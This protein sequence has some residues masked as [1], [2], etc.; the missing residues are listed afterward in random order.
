MAAAPVSWEKRSKE[1]AKYEKAHKVEPD[2]AD[3][4]QAAERML[5]L[6]R[7][8]VQGMIDDAG[9][10]AALGL[11]ADPAPYKQVIAK[12]DEH[13]ADTTFKLIP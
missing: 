1:I 6:Y 3:R 11:A 9:T 12:A 5:G 4:E 13:M 7:K 2:K 8:A 10:F